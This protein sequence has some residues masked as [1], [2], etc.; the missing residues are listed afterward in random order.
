MRSI[1]L[2]DQELEFMREQHSEEL[3]SAEKYIEQ[4]KEVL[5]KIGGSVKPDK[6]EPTEKEPK[7][8]KKR[9]RKT[10]VKVIEPKEP[11]KRGRPKTVPTGES[12][13]VLSQKRRGRK[14]K[15]VVPTLEKAESAIATPIAKRNIKKVT[16]KPRRKIATKPKV[17]KKAVIK[18]TPKVAPSPEAVPSQEAKPALKKEIKQVVKKKVIKRRAPKRGVRLAP[19]SKPLPKKE[20]VAETP[21]Q[22]ES[23][24]ENPHPIEL[25]NPSVD[26]VKE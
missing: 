1:K 10:K 15:A 18:K 24:I 7:Q 17:A 6:E 4:I 2:T 8:R 25:P 16:P 5:R 12:K 19:L 21:P 23:A 22:N 9:G 11:K 20:P 13:T 3:A 26:E 14:P